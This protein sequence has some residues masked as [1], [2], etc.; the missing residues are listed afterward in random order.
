MV[1]LGW[2]VV[3]RPSP[4][5]L[6]LPA[7]KSRGGQQRQACQHDEGGPAPASPPAP[8]REDRVF[9]FDPKVPVESW[10]QSG[11]DRQGQEIC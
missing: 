2:T 5:L 4:L 7:R 10:C 6:Q 9:L 3:E 8:W 11:E 1:W